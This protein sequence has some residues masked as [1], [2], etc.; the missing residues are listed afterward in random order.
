MSRIWNVGYITRYWD[1]SNSAQFKNTAGKVPSSSDRLKV[2][3]GYVIIDF[4]FYKNS[5]KPP[6]RSTD[7]L[8]FIKNNPLKKLSNDKYP[9]LVKSKWMYN[10]L[11]K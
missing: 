9:L 3:R 5:L 2:K 7:Q 1:W 11:F 6:L 10:Q 8:L 4:I